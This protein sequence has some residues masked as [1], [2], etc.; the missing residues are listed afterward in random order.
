MYSSDVP[1][2]RRRR[3]Q[4]RT[5]SGRTTGSAPPWKMRMG[6]WRALAMNASVPLGGAGH[7]GAMAAQ[8]SGRVRPIHN[9]P[10]PPIERP[11]R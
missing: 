6:R 11:V 9:V 3:T 7:T 4:V 10:P 5:L 1:N 2:A 8:M